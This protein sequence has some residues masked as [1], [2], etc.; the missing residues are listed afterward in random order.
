MWSATESKT[1]VLDNSRGQSHPPCSYCPLTVDETRLSRSDRWRW[2]QP[3]GRIR[4][5]R[6][7]DEK[8]SAVFSAEAARYRPP[9][10]VQRSNLAESRWVALHDASMINRRLRPPVRP[11]N[12]TADFPG[13]QNSTATAARR[14]PRDPC[15]SRRQARWPRAEPQT[16]LIGE[17]DAHFDGGRD[18]SADAFGGIQ[19]FDVHEGMP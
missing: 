12:A 2:N 1:R 11:A 14:D 6:S 19:R 4:P 16:S 7:C 5:R 10:C 17:D 8:M 3:T 15:D 18:A 13:P 9:P